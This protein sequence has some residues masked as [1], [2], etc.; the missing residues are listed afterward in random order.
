MVGM[1]LVLLAVI[2]VGCWLLVGYG[3]A[4]FS[5]RTAGVPWYPFWLTSAA[6]NGLAALGAGF[7]VL[8]RLGLSIDGESVFIGL[9]LGWM[10]AMSVLS[11]LIALRSPRAPATAASPAASP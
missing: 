3:R 5:A 4:Y 8:Y 6:Y 2:S 7:T 10:C 1:S 9:C 11:I